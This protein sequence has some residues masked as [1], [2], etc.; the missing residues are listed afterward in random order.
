MACTANEWTQR[1]DPRV[2]HVGTQRFDP[3][4]LHVYVYVN[5]KLIVFSVVCFLLSNLFGFIDQH[6]VMFLL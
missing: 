4:V 3:R 6:F 5:R 1:S 2:L